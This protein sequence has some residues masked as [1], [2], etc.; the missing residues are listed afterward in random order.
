M[1]ELRYPPRSTTDLCSVR[2]ISE[3]VAA[4]IAA[5]ISGGLADRPVGH[6][7]YALGLVGIGIGTGIGIGIELRSLDN[8]FRTD[9]DADAE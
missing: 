3:V 2:G 7:P 4:A 9:S 1:D 6:P 8:R 5:E